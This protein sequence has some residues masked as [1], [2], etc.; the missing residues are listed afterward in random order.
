MIILGQSWGSTTKH[1]FN[2]ALAATRKVLTNGSWSIGQ[3]SFTQHLKAR[4]VTRQEHEKLACEARAKCQ[5]SRPKKHAKKE[6]VAF[7][8]RGV[9]AQSWPSPKYLGVLL[10]NYSRSEQY[11][12]WQLTELCDT[13]EKCKGCSL[14]IFACATVYNVFFELQVLH[15]SCV[16]IQ[17]LQSIFADWSS[18]WERT[19]HINL[20]R[21]IYQGGLSTAHL[22]LGRLSTT[23]SMGRRLR[24][25]FFA[26]SVRFG[27]DGRCPTLSFLLRA[28]SYLKDVTCKLLTANF[29]LAYQSSVTRKQLYRN[30]VNSVLRVPLNQS[31]YNS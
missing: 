11:S 17:Q 29:S 14:W 3:C 28:F 13:T 25:H 19:T 15:C 23:F 16:N 8:I 12:R 18:L 24:T 4:A 31:L 20:F 30:L 22:F 5:K 2:V 9:C 21:S 10:G 26:L 1:S 6:Q 7:G 27:S